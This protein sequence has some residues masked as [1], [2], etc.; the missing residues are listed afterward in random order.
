MASMRD[1]EPIRADDPLI[2]EFVEVDGGR[3][4]VLHFIMTKDGIKNEKQCSSIPLD[5]LESVPT[6]TDCYNLSFT[7]FSLPRLWN[8]PVFTGISRRDIAQ[9]CNTNDFPRYILQNSSPLVGSSW[10]HFW[11]SDTKVYCFAYSRF[12]RASRFLSIMMAFNTKKK[13]GNILLGLNESDLD[14]SILPLIRESYQDFVSCPESIYPTIVREQY[15]KLEVWINRQIDL[16]GRLQMYL[17]GYQG[18]YGPLQQPGPS[19]GSLSSVAFRSFQ[20]QQANQWVLENLLRTVEI[21]KTLQ[22]T[23]LDAEARRRLEIKTGALLFRIKQ[24]QRF[25][26]AEL[27]VLDQYFFTIHHRMTQ[28][29][30]NKSNRIAAEVWRDSTA[31]RTIAIVTLVFLPPTFISSV[32]STTIFNFQNWGIQGESV[33]NNGAWV[34]FVSIVGAT[35]ITFTVWWLFSRANSRQYTS[36]KGDK[37]GNELTDVQLQDLEGI[38]YIYPT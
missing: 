21:S 23:D 5:P 8:R 11:V 20:Q 31:M 30:A 1:W 2:K 37:T 24:V 25:C 22:L 38:Q 35:L 36:F 33:A 17:D 32:F 28:E 13:Q 16:R 27:A 10:N 19:L 7:I 9:W 18:V 29:D 12:R 6:A 34:F 26:A 4:S 3:T 15:L 14:T